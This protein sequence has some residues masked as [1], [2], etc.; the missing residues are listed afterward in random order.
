MLALIG[1]ALCHHSVA[2]AETPVRP[3][4][5]P[6]SIQTRV[7]A[8]GAEV[9]ANLQRHADDRHTDDRS[10]AW[11]HPLSSAERTALKAEI[12]D[13]CPVRV[14]DLVAIDVRFRRADGS[15]GFGRLIV[16]NHYSS[17]ALEKRKHPRPG[18][19]RKLQDIRE[20][21][22]I[23]RELAN[24]F[25]ANYRADHPYPVQHVI[26][27]H[28]FRRLADSRAMEIDDLSM[29]YNNTYAFAARRVIATDRW[30]RHAI[31]ALDIN[32]FYNPFILRTEKGRKV[33]VAMSS[34]TQTALDADLIEVSPPG[35]EHFAFE[36][37]QLDDPHVIN[38][39]NAFIVEYLDQRGWSWGGGFKTMKDYHHF[40]PR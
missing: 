32:P 15:E 16:A 36:R 11:I 8:L 29:Q 31:G 25:I 17:A 39:T 22:D 27:L 13:D 2:F 30:S 34:L 9:Q 35:S 5:L 14:E 20:K 19:W 24:F 1:A 23:A 28:Y 26:P 6:R 33:G 38:D 40:A 18:Y 4:P 21:R 3:E 12:P 37:S 7:D 10:I